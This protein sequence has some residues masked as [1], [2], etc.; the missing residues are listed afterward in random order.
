M[1]PRVI[2]LLAPLLFGCPSLVAAHDIPAAVTVR[3]FAKPEAARLRY[4]VRIPMAS[5]N[6]IEWPLRKEDG[7]LE[8]D[9]IDRALRDAATLWVG[10]NAEWY[11]MRRSSAPRR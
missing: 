11:K 8:L 3:M 6:D 10:D 7:T 9:R 1:R 5:I 2:A 4:L